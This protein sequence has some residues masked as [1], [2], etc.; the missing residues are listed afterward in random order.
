MDG[1]VNMEN[2]FDPTKPV[3]YR[4]GEPARVVSVVSCNVYNS[5]PQPV[6]SEG[7]PGIFRTH[8]T[9]G[10]FLSHINNSTYD[11]INIPEEPKW[12]AWKPEEVPVGALIRNKGRVNPHSKY[13]V[14]GYDDGYVLYG[15]GSRKARQS[16]FDHCEHSIDNG[17][18][19]LPCGV[20]E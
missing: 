19:W 3:R 2:K 10:R 1:G 15:H 16:C 14:A 6:V 17:K 9:D 13:V 4:N 7:Q 5:E 20:K 18:T 11:L 8:F 12:R